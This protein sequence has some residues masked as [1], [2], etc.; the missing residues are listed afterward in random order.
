ML[1]FYDFIFTTMCLIEIL[2][3]IMYLP[4]IY[5]NGILYHYIQKVHNYLYQFI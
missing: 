3:N 4:I 1:H 5:Y 2:Y